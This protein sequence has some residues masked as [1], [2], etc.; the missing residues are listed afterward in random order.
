MDA[1]GGKRS[2]R[3]LRR[4]LPECAT[5]RPSV[6]RLRCG[7]RIAIGPIGRK[8]C[9]GKR[10]ETLEAGEHSWRRAPATPILRDRRNS[11]TLTGGIFWDE[12]Q[13]AKARHAGR[14][15]TVQRCL[16]G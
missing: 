15:E 14:R 9:R 5:G 13:R 7:S 6:R 1:A 8:Y 2:K 16:G 4:F 12:R 3:T 10:Q 11:T